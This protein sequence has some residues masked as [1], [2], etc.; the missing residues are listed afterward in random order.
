MDNYFD[1]AFMSDE[2][3]ELAMD[4]IINNMK[5]DLIREETETTIINPV[6][7]K[8]F[9]FAYAALQYIMKDQNVRLSYK[10]YEPFKTMGSVTVEGKVLEFCKPEWFARIAE[11]ASNTEVYPLAKNAVR[12]TFTFHGLTK[13]MK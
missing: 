1:F 4:E 6:R 5:E 7:I 12:M 11:F 10:M 13:P 3:L 2:E 8:Q 9:Q